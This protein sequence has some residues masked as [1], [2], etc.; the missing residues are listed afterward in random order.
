MKT[1]FDG[2]VPGDMCVC[3]VRHALENPHHVFLGPCPHD[4]IAY[5]PF[6]GDL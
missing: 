2:H 1:K 5:P 4:T 6:G 3:R